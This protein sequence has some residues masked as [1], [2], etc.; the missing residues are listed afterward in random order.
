MSVLGPKAWMP[1][2]M[3]DADK[4]F[5]I[6]N[7]PGDPHAAAAEA[8]EAWAASLDGSNDSPVTHVATG[9]QSITYASG[10]SPTRNAQARAV[11]HRARARAKSFELGGPYTYTS[12]GGGEVTP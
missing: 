3:L 4:D 6:E 5:F 10:A 12:N 1:K 8:W 7:N 2:D 9:A 11:Y